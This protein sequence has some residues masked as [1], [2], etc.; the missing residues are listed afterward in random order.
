MTHHLSLSFQPAFSKLGKAF[1]SYVQPETLERCK[2]VHVNSRLCKDYGIADNFD[3][4]QLL[5]PGKLSPFAS[6]YSGH[7]FGVWAGQ[8]GDGR[9]ITYGN[10]FNTNRS[11]SYT[12]SIEVQLKGA[13]KTPYSRFADGRAVLRSTI[14][15]YLAGEALFHLGIPST[16][17]LAILSSETDVFREQ[18][19]K[20]AVLVRCAATHIRF[21]HFEHFFYN[22]Q[23]EELEKLANFVKQNFYTNCADY[24]TMFES[25]VLKTASLVAHWQVYGFCHGVLNTDNMSIIGDTLDYGPYGFMDTFNP[26]WICNHSDHQGRYS[27]KNQPAIGLWNCNALAHAMSLLVEVESIKASLHQYES[28]FHHIYYQLLLERLGLENSDS[29][30]QLSNEFLEQLAQ[31][32]L[33]M[34]LGFLQLPKGYL[35][36]L[37]CGLDKQWITRY[38][39]ANPCFQ[40]ARKKNPAYILRN[41]MAQQAINAAEQGDYSILEKLFAVL[42]MPFQQHSGCESWEQEPP[43]W[44]NQLELSCSS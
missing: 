13:G 27:Y 11:R 9:A 26:N 7:Q 34:N 5:E 18:V 20:A 14:R 17:A 3:F 15:E 25:I 40:T 41:Y 39:D 36:L 31:K 30:K 22:K 24:A 32:R 2:T 37:N 12:N 4:C 8:L 1:I 23:H 28:Y 21:G 44:A 6:V 33:D 38:L 10:L 42:Q 35:T 19:E 43:E 16:R 29:N